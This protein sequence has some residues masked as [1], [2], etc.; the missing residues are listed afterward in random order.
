MRHLVIAVIFILAC[1]LCSTV[2]A[3]DVQKSWTVMVYANFANGDASDKTPEDLED[4]D[5]DVD[6]R[7]IKVLEKTGTTND[8]NIIVERQYLKD[9]FTARI[10]IEKSNSP[11]KV[12]SPV[13]QNLGFVDM[14]NYLTLQDFIEWGVKNYPAQHYMI[15]VNAHGDGWY[16]NSKKTLRRSKT[17]DMSKDIFTGTSI[18]SPQLGK[19]LQHAAELIGHKIDVVGLDSCYMLD[20]ETV[21]ELTGS[22]H[23]VMGS[24]DEENS[25]A[26]PYETLSAQIAKTPAITPE[27]LVKF[28][29]IEITALYQH[30]PN[31][32]EQQTFA[33]VDVDRIPALNQAVSKLAYDIAGNQHPEDLQK[34]LQAQQN[35]LMMQNSGV[36]FDLGDFITELKRAQIKSLDQNNLADI[37]KLLHQAVMYQFINTNIYASEDH[38]SRYRQLGGV[39]IWLS[40]QYYDVNA[41]KNYHELKFDND[42]KW[43]SA[44][45]AWGKTGP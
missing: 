14:G 3:S 28:A 9:K 30:P 19:A 20:I 12:T 7:L 41:M 33:V 27:Q 23:L 17:R 13:L 24:E 42:T 45:A 21:T 25:E 15:I 31:K 39:G 5:H 2:Q 1:A 43:G 38:N 8:V 22:T 35:V 29:M 18:T 32:D 34:I 40:G 4:D 6:Q 36:H 16:D 44:I 26:W 37:E 11:D 10:Q